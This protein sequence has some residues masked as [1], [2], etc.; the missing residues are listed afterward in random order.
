MPTNFSSLQSIKYLLQN[1]MQNIFINIF[2]L[3]KYIHFFCNE[4]DG[5]KK[6]PKRLFL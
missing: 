1:A 5:G 2:K 4:K 3:Y 6:G